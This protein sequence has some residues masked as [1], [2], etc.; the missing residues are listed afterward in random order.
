MNV[1]YQAAITAAALVGV[2]C[3]GGAAGHP[4]RFAVARTKTLTIYSVATNEQFMNHEDDRA[5]GKGN[6]PFGNYKDTQTATKEAGTGPF[7]G[8]R[9]IFTFALY[10]NAKLKNSV[11]SATFICQYSFNKNALC[12]TAYVLNGG[13]LLG[14]GSFNFNATTFAVAI[15]GGTNKYRSVTGDVE[16]T[17]AAKHSQHLVFTLD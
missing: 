9:A 11:G 3:V 16:A 15:T 12:D 5:R 17:P 13:T 10:A 4:S 2:V 6:N 7:A 8:D 14:A 1:R